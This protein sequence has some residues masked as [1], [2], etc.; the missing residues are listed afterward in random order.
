MTQFVIAALLAIV[1]LLCWLGVVGMLRMREPMEA[2]HYLALP[3]SAGMV[4]LCVAVFLAQGWGQV[5]LKTVLIAVILLTFNSVVTH[6]TARAF[7]VRALGTG[8]SPRT[9]ALDYEGVRT[10]GGKA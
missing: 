3:A 5:S 8:A 7:R 2:L 1:V 4:L 10:K 6:A 9:D